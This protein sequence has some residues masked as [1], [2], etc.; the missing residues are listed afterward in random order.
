MAQLDNK[1]EQVISHLLGLVF[2]F[3][4]WKKCVL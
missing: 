1:A 2:T 4:L 3:C